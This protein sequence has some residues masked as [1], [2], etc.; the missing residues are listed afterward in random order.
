MRKDEKKS[1]NASAIF[2]YKRSEFCWCSPLL[3][4]VCLPICTR[5]DMKSAIEASRRTA[6]AWENR[7]ATVALS[8]RRIAVIVY[9]VSHKRCNREF[10]FAQ[11]FQRAKVVKFSFFFFILGNYRWKQKSK[12]ESR[13]PVSEWCMMKSRLCW[14]RREASLVLLAFDLFTFRTSMGK[15]RRWL[16]ASCALR[17]FLRSSRH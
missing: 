8:P 5:A 17:F 11:F 16:I 13:A 1:I 2:P 9:I 6:T 4:F 15:S 7:S 10:S 3:L 12:V 14:H